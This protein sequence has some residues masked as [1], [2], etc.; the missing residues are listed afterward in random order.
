MIGG[1]LDRGELGVMVALPKHGKTTT[2]VNL[3]ANSL[4]R[5]KNVLHFTLELSQRMIASKYDTCLFQ[6]T[7]LSIKSKPKAF[8][9]AILNLHKKLSSRLFIAEYPTKSLTLDRI[10]SIIRRT[11]NVGLVIIDYGQLIKSSRV[12][13]ELH[14]EL[15]E[16]YEGLRRVAGEHK[17]PIWTAH[18]AN[19]PGT[20]SKVIRIEHIAGD[21]NVAA[22]A[23]VTV[24]INQSEEETLRNQMRLYVMGN[25]LGPSGEAI[26]C[27]VN[28]KTCNINQIGVEELNSGLV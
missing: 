20:S 26:N 23:D 10:G 22:I 18:Q 14:H 13:N 15:T 28:W 3:G 16:I 6:D 7:L 9:E 1:G 8:A 19:R 5:D 21:F 17:V 4:M 27:N 2:L 11:G 24:S 12:R 25:R